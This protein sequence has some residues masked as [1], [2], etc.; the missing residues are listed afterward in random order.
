MNKQEIY[1]NVARGWNTWNTRNALDSVLLP[2]GLSIDIGFCLFGKLL[3]LTEAFFGKEYKGHSTGCEL[4]NKNSIFNNRTIQVIPG[5]HSYNGSYTSLTVIIEDVKFIVQTAHNGEKDI[6]ILVTPEGREIKTPV[7]MI[8]VGMLWNMPGYAVLEADK[9]KAVVNQRQIDIYT[10]GTLVREA[11]L[12]ARCPYFAVKMDE[13]VGVST[14]HKL[15]VAQIR[16]I[17][18]RERS[19]AEAVHQSYETLCDVHKAMQNCTAWNVVYEPQGRRVICT[20]SRKWNCLRL[21]YGLFGWDSFFAAW[22]MSID[23][24]D[25]AYN[26]FFQTLNDMIDGRYVANVIN[27]SG[28]KSIGRSNPPIGA[29]TAKFIYSIHKEKWFIEEVFKPLL[30][31]NRWWPQRRLNELGLLS[32][33]SEPF[34]PVVGD[35][36]E[37]IQQNNLWGACL[38]SGLD[39][40]PMY[41]DIAFDIDSCIMKLADVGLNSLYVSDCRILAEFADL[42]GLENEAVELRERCARFGDKLKTLWSEADGIFLNRKTDTGDFSPKLSP[43]LFYPMLTGIPTET[44]AKQMVRGHLYNPDE[45]W[46]EWILPSIARNVPAYS[47]Q[48]YWRGRIWAPMNFLTY[49]GLK[50]YRQ[51]QAVA[52]ITDKSR[53]LLRKNLEMD[54][55]LYE[56]Y[57]GNTGY[58]NNVHNSEPYLNFGSLLA[59]IPLMEQNKY[60]FE[61]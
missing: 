36:A 57:C 49:L 19:K 2:E 20:P 8:Q 42:L 54:G 12:P 50:K 4:D 43:T 48:S 3:T 55:L 32:W 46:G 51:K 45:F 14:N 40:S 16:E 6:V 59:L 56:N 23:N 39:N 24:K 29:M 53:R 27:G 61:I 18:N 41:D 34:E 25:F 35:P 58:G 37:I 33:G 60:D 15:T 21:G 13:E 9:I 11:N 38:E 30:T 17:V 47:D 1:S 26:V 31:W 7:M 5:L 28:R 10:T 52:D 44:Q 22:M